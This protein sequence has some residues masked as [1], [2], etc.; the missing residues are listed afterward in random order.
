[1]LYQMTGI[2]RPSPV[3]PWR[4]GVSSGV[5]DRRTQHEVEPTHTAHPHG[6][7]GT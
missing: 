1:M 7:D 2:H 5:N 6:S 4:E 3:K